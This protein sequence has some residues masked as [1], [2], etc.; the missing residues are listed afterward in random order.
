M[1]LFPEVVAQVGSLL[2]FFHFSNFL[3]RVITIPSYYPLNNQHIK[4]YSIWYYKI[5]TH[6]GTNQTQRRLTLLIE[7]EQVFQPDMATV[8]SH[9]SE[10]V[11]FILPFY[12]D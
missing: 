1:H 3:L 6:I 7:R 10:N 11:L 2:K 12:Y 9:A 5:V 4:A 8:I